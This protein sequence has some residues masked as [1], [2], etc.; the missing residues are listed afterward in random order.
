LFPSYALVLCSQNWET[1]KHCFLYP[2]VLKVVITENICFL[3]MFP[4][5]GLT[6]KHCFLAMLSNCTQYKY[7]I[8]LINNFVLTSRIHSNKS[9][10]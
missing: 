9:Q 7:N 1:R 10:I 6:K 4:E 8:D 2:C 5:D 3:A